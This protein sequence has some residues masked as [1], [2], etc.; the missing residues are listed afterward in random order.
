MNLA[1][2]ER[3][4]DWPARMTAEIAA[5][6]MGVSKTTFL[7]RFGATGVKEGTNVLWAKVQLDSM[8]AKQFSIKQPRA[9]AQDRD[10]SWDDF[11]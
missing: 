7:T 9:G 6:Y 11:R 1:R 2:L 3:L 10:T 8:I 4:P 5:A